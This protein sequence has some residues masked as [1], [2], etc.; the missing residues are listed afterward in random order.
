MAAI[1]PL[2]PEDEI[3]YRRRYKQAIRRLTKERDWLQAQVTAGPLPDMNFAWAVEDMERIIW[4]L[5]QEA[6]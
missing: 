6:K 3:G 1:Q 5:Q 2:T 4:Q